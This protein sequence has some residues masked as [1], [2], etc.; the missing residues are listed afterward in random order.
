[1]TKQDFVAWKNNPVTKQVFAGLR[2]RE[3]DKA[4]DLIQAAGLDPLQDR[5]LSGYI[6]ALR[7]FYLIEAEDGDA[8]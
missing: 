5:Y 4:E 6:A 1:M 8:E 7:D 3:Q 2:E